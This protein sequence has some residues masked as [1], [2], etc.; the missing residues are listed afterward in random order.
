MINPGFPNLGLAISVAL[1]GAIG[2]VLRYVLWHYFTPWFGPVFP[3][4][5]FVANVF[6]SLWLGFFGALAVT[7][8]GSLDPLLRFFL[9]TGFAGGLTTFSTLAFDTLA[10]YERGDTLI[11]VGNIVLNVLIG[12]I[13]V[14]LGA[15][16]ARSL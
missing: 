5:T 16:I 13:A 7:K 4:G 8:P 12:M 3:W 11:A 6:G 10:I 2:S 14:V 9:T 15:A 1:G